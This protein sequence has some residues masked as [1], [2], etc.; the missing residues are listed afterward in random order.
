[1]HI[2]QGLMHII[3]GGFDWASTV[4]TPQ[5]V[6]E[7]LPIGRIFHGDKQRISFSEVVPLCKIS[8]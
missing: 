5:P 7:V 4:Q 1:M 2:S 3:Q 8:S 6:A